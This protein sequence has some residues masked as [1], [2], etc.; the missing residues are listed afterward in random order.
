MT[1]FTKRKRTDYIAVHC[2]A[3]PPSFNGGAK[4]IRKW[5]RDKGWI[6]IGYHA[7]IRRDGTIEWGRPL[8]TV[9]AHVE[10][11]NAVS[12]GVCL[13]GGVNAKGQPEDNFTLAQYAALALLLRE[14][15]KLYPAAKIQGH[16]DFPNVK[17]ACPS[18]DVRKWINEMGVFATS[19]VPDEPDTP[20]IEVKSGDTLWSIS[21]RYG[22]TVAALL[23]V[24]PQIE[25]SALKIGTLLR[26][27]H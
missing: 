19:K 9:G 1:L 15:K 12:V 18:F 23:K 3:T 8:D 27:P 17:K 14:W 10:N 11:F 24:N 22:T 26:L 20:A 7:V 25:V 13:V 2:A 21:K 5:H 6:D 16:R 4:E